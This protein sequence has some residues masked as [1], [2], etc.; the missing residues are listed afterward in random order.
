[1]PEKY[2]LIGIKYGNNLSARKT[3]AEIMLL[4]SESKRRAFIIPVYGADYLLVSAEDLQFAMSRL[5]SAGFR[6]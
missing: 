1:M 6:E 2:V 4:I 5:R 3:A